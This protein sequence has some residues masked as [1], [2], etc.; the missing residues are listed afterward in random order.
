MMFDFNF[1]NKEEREEESNEYFLK[2]FPFGIE[3]REAVEDLLNDLFPLH[4][5]NNLMF[6]YIDA[7]DKY[8]ENKR[9]DGVKNAYKAIKKIKPYFTV[10]EQDEMFRLI[11]LD[12]VLNNLDEF[13]IIEEVRIT[14]NN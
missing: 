11:E 2:L 1:K 12:T 4:K 9:N 7:K 3:Q 8:I 13:P 10:S 5:K 14:V 6:H